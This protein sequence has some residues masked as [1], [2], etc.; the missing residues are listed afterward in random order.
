MPNPAE[1]VDLAPGDPL[2]LQFAPDDT[3]ARLQVQVIGLLP[4]G[5]V[6][7][8][9]PVEHQSL[10][11][12]R[13]GQT[14]IARSFL[15]K[16]VVAFPCRVLRTCMHPYAYV[17]LSY[18]EHLEKVLVR[19]ARRV[20]TSLAATV[21]REHGDGST[22]LPAPATLSD[23]S[24][25]GALLQTALVLAPGQEQVRIS[26]RL[27]M[28]QMDEQIIAVNGAVTVAYQDDDANGQRYGI[29]FTE[30]GTPSK[31]ALR[32]YVYENLLGDEK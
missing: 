32:A 8:T 6:I 20:A 25:S 21:Q 31:L 1:K 5:S 28:D 18:P 4:G 19:G 3:R 16:R 15:R 22:S 9:A 30:L 11:L 17:H 10:V 12:L 13:E 14:F 7:V 23:L 2:Q 26:V 24:T 29:R 27:P